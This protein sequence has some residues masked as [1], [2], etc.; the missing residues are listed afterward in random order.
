MQK[1]TDTADTFAGVGVMTP[2]A[3]KQNEEKKLPEKDSFFSDKK[4]DDETNA[5]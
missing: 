2:P 5:T 3:E 4:I 1:I